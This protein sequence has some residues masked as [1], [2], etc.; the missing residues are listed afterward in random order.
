LNPPDRAAD[1]TAPTPPGSAT[2]AS[3][4]SAPAAHK[5]SG[6]T[7]RVSSE[8]LFGG[9]VEVQIEHRGALYRLKQTA[10]GKLILTK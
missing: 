4:S 6:R 9:A 1:A 7:A 10:L 3:A 2:L 5:S 8:H